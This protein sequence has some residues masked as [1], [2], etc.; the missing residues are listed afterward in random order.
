MK[1][2]YTVTFRYEEGDTWQEVFDTLE[3]ATAACQEA[4][5]DGAECLTLVENLHAQG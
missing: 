1:T 5:S 2:T 3:E 4:R